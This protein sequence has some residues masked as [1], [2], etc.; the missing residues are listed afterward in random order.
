MT[1][2]ASDFNSLIQLCHNVFH[3]CS[4]WLP[5]NRLALNVK[6]TNFMIIG[7]VPKTFMHLYHLIIVLLI[8]YIL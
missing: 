1:V 4:T 8:G 7:N 6:K 5:D 2:A 3:A